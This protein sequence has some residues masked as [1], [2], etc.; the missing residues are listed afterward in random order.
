MAPLD[1]VMDVL[2][3]SSVA[4]SALWIAERFCVPTI[5][6]RRHITEDMRP[7]WTVGLEGP[8]GVLIRSGLWTRLS[9]ATQSIAPFLVE[10]G[11]RT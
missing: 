4:D 6:K 7:V 1:L 2:G 9:E 11:Q 3:Q 8:L 5:P 10:H